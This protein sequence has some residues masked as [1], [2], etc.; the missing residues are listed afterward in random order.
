MKSLMKPFLAIILLAFGWALAT[1]EALAI[2]E[3][4]LSE[5]HEV[6]QPAPAV[7]G[8]VSWTLFAQTREVMK[9]VDG[10][11]WIAP[12]FPAEL[13]ALSGKVVKVNGFMMPLQQAERQSHFL[14]MAYPISCPFCLSIG[15]AQ[16]VEIKA[17]EGI[18][19]S[20]E[21]MLVEG[22]LELLEIDES[23][24]FFRLKD[25]RIARS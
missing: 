15:P 5:D 25:A 18:A 17:R 13:K 7:D 4:P 22:T 23:G 20:Y 1:P 3:E 24:L 9:E 16:I 6:W 8:S 12:D 19:F 11:P 10:E 14:L 21:P 2:R